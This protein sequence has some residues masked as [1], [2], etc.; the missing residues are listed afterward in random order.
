MERTLS[1]C[2]LILI[3]GVML[4][5]CAADVPR[6]VAS[7]PDGLG[8]HRAVIRVADKGDAVLARIP[9][10]RRDDDQHLKGVIITDTAGNRLPNVCPVRMNRDFGEIVFEADQPGEY[11]V[12]YMPFTSNPV[13]W[14]YSVTYTP[15]SNRA[16]PAWL[17]RHNLNDS[18]PHPEAWESLPLAEVIEIQ[19]RSEFDRF[20]PMEVTSTWEEMGLG[21]QYPGPYWVFPED[22]EHPIRMTRDLPRRWTQAGPK[23]EFQG[24]ACRGEFYAFQLGVYP[25]SRELENVDIVFTDLRSEDGKV[26]PSSALR[27]FNAG[28]TDWLGRPMKAT[29]NLDF[30]V[31][32][33]WFGVQV[34]KEASP[35]RYTGIITLKPT[36][37]RESSIRLVLQ[38]NDK[39]LDDAGDSDI[40]RLSR[41]RWLDS[42]IGLDDEVTAPYTPMK[43]RGRTVSCLGR[44]VKIADTGLPASIKSGGRE[45]L[46]RP[47][48]FVVE[49]DKGIVEFKGGKPKPSKA[50]PGSVTWEAESTGGDLT[51]IC[52]A[53]MEFDGY[54][55]FRVSVKSQ[56]WINAKD[57]RLEIPIKREVATYMMGLGREGGFRPE[58]WEWAWDIDRC[59]NAVWIGD[60]EAGLQCKLKG[61]EDT[62]DIYDLSAGGIPESWGNGGKGGCTVREVGDE[63][64][65]RAYTGARKLEAGQEIEFRFGMLITPV[66]PLDPAHWD[67]R[68]YHAYVPPETAIASGANIVNIHHGN[69]LNP[70]INYP[71]LTARKLSAYVKDAHDKG[72]KVKIYYTVRELSNHV[73]EMW[74]LRSLGHEIFTGGAGGGDAWLREHLVSDYAAAWHQ[75]LPGGEVDAAIA[76]TGLSRWH[77][78]YLE[79]LGWLVR[80]VGIDGLYL[81]GIGY[82]REIMRR[83][84]KVLDNSKPG[85]LID[86]HSGNEFP[87]HD[88]RVSPANKYMEHFPYINSL[89]FGEG[90]DYNNE[91]PDYWLVE[92][93]GIP[94]GL[95]GEMLHDN[96]N[97]W[98]GM[99]YG[100]TARY[101]SGADP[102]HIWRLW[103]DF[104]IRDAEMIGYWSPGCP[105]RTDHQGVLATVYRRED[106]ALISLAS[107]EKDPARVRLTIDWKSLG[108]DPAK[109]RFTAPAIPGFQD[110]A[111]FGPSDEIP[112]EP[113]RGWL[114]IAA[115][116]P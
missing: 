56:G 29:L 34:P 86:F 93:S 116:A 48:T 91:P 101:Y 40:S 85:C 24:E 54:T 16:D 98:R 18:V 75:P 105:I 89:W 27:C 20:D 61:P 70:Y 111:S 72:V 108:L 83:V 44:Q 94:F 99:V 82:D 55:D 9:W 49:T 81:D 45:I 42:T 43:V 12:Y 35:G 38:V 50:G 114:L 104:G 68:Y 53:R 47:M 97:P 58:K 106:R 5:C 26:I 32:A 41:L 69:E 30:S 1:I 65:V 39:V 3:G 21:G 80:N 109:A 95:Y 92:V 14:D 78:Y 51:L 77:N 64:V 36:N 79:G 76:T 96:G 60:V 31:H 13:P 88:L 115:E 57:F 90:Y 110:A 46:A 100:M 23:D 15:D 17:Q 25:T 103:D 112:V 4:S 33:L 71:F 67:Q 10:R 107:W 2:I 74:A 113:G 59:N 37:V 102:K 52:R 8:N 22:R 73:A 7:W 66:K 87:F 19:A 62:W 84:R 63:V 28:G 11:Y 6:G